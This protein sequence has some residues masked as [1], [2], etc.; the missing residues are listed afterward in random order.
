MQALNNKSAGA[1]SLAIAA[2]T[3]GLCAKLPPMESRQVRETHAYNDYEH[4]QPGPGFEI[5]RSGK[6]SSYYYSGRYYTVEWIKK[7]PNHQATAIRNS[8]LA[9]TTGLLSYS[10]IYFFNS[11]M[12]LTRTKGYISNVLKQ[13]PLLHSLHIMTETENFGDILK[14]K[15]EI[16]A[17]LSKTDILK[18]ISDP[19][20]PFTLNNELKKYTALQS[21]L[22]GAERHLR[23]LAHKVQPQRA[24]YEKLTQANQT[25]MRAHHALQMIITTIRSS[26][27]YQQELEKWA[28]MSIF[29][30]AWYGLTTYKF[31][32]LIPQKN[33]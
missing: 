21:A 16:T 11:E 17:I 4:K 30:K 29:Q 33:Q 28:Q 23:W 25:Y 19:Q 7:T 22:T 14:E 8:I 32:S 2:T 24:L 1:L 5:F 13:I 18:E 20:D 26:E 10:L 31:P 27:A 12:I 15:E 9:A 3:F 6:N